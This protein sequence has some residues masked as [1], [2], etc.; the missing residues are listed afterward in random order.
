M[1]GRSGAELARVRAMHMRLLLT[2][3]NDHVARPIG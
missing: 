2:R 1:R 3:F